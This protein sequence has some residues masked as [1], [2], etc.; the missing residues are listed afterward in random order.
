[1]QLKEKLIKE[2]DKLSSRELGEIYNLILFVKSQQKIEQ[3]SYTKQFQ[4]V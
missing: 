3:E 1:M 4:S 2:I